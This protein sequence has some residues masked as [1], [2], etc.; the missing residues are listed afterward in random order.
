MTAISTC[1]LASLTFLLENTPSGF[2]L[3]RELP[4]RLRPLQGLH[5]LPETVGRT[6]IAPLSAGL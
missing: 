5:V 4:F 2:L 6:Q 1:A 3:L